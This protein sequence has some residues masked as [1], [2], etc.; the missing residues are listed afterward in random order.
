MALHTSE[1]GAAVHV[2][3]LLNIS[4]RLFEELQKLFVYSGDSLFARD[5]TVKRKLRNLFLILY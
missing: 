5:L 4:L 1:K 3:P 2:S